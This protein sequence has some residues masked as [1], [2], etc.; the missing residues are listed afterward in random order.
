MHW[1]PQNEYS[2]KRR[3]LVENFGSR[4]RLRQVKSQD[5]NRVT[6]DHTAAIGAVNSV[7]DDRS[8]QRPTEERD[9]LSELKTQS[10]PAFD[11]ETESVNEVYA[12]HGV[13]SQAEW[14]LLESKQML[15]MVKK[16]SVLEAE[17]DKYSLCVVHT[18]RK[19]VSLERGEKRTSAKC[20]AYVQLLIDFYKLPRNKSKVI[21]QLG[22]AYGYE[23]PSL[24]EQI[25]RKFTARNK[26][27]KGPRRFDTASKDKLLNWIFIGMLWA[28]K[29]N[30]DSG[31]VASLSKDLKMG[32]SDVLLYF[33]EVGCRID[34][35]AALLTAPLTFPKMKK[36]G[37]GQ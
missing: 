8:N 37:K 32:V 34:K 13:I 33:K 28:N 19:L 7:L 16:P 5:A 10:L 2:L 9:I 12:L 29:F 24:M 4:K 15:E 26:A 25:L 1:V 36:P 21:D 17:K 11:L 27:K 35:K 14:S 20:L 23:S 22:E 3:M 18:L 31:A 30:V 6:L